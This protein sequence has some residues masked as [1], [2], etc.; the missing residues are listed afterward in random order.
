MLLSKNNADK[1]VYELKTIGDEELNDI[2]IYLKEFFD[3]L[4]EDPKSVASLLINAN[5]KEIEKTLLPLFANNFYEN[6]LSQK[7]VQNN[8]LYII[9]LLLKHEIKTSSN[10][11][12]PKSFLNIKSP[13][14]YLLYE[15]RNKRDFQIFLKSTIEEAVEIIEYYPYDIYFNIDKIDFDIKQQYNFKNESLEIN[16]K[17]KPSDNSEFTEIIKIKKR[18]FEPN[19]M[20]TI[21]ALKKNIFQ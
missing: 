4:W 19:N 21:E 5:P 12:F 17:K 6:I 18:E 11:S 16:T 8:L 13:C 15:F 10:L 3:T 9:T 1:R 2:R 20:K 7:F 14:G